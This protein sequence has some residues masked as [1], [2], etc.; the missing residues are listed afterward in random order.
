MEREHNLDSRQNAIERPVSHRRQSGCVPDRYSISA[1][2]ASSL[3]C[4]VAPSPRFGSRHEPARQPSAN[5]L[6]LTAFGATTRRPG[7]HPAVRAGQHFHPAARCR[8]CQGRHSC[9]PPT[10]EPHV[11]LPNH[12]QGALST[13]P[14]S[15]TPG[16]PPE[17][18]GNRN[19]RSSVVISLR[20]ATRASADKPMKSSLVPACCRKADPAGRYPRTGS[21]SEP[22]SSTSPPDDGAASS[23]RTEAFRRPRPAPASPRRVP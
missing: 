16:R 17:H 3:G 22:A 6:I 19:K 21:S 1:R 8:P 10:G 23:T 7:G 15:A 14:A 11:P 20:F 4:G 9:W 13:A 2:S 18:P 5:G 12:R